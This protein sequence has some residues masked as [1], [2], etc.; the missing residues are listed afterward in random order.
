MFDAA[1]SE[2]NLANSAL[3]VHSC[4]DPNTGEEL[5]EEL[6]SPSDYNGTDPVTFSIEIKPCAEC[7]AVSTWGYA[8]LAGLVLISG[9]ML[10]RRYS[11]NVGLVRA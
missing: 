5:L 9:G 3:C 11:S 2:C 10:F 4:P 7:P 1:I 6:E 8:L